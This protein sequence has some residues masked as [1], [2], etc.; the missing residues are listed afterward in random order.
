MA[1]GFSLIEAL[2]ATTILTGALVV[3]TQLALLSIR[4]NQSAGSI[5][6]TTILAAQK[7]EQLRALAWT[8]DAA[9]VPVSDTFTDTTGTEMPAGGTGL[10]LSPSAALEENT[11]GYCDFLDG[12]G[13]TIGRGIN[14]PANTV[15][16]RRWSIDSLSGVAN[17]TLVLQVSVTHI[18][19]RS[20]G[21]RVV[22]I[23]TRK[24]G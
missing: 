4:A 16:V 22:G 14:A 18:G 7:M 21:T 1:R 2:F 17:D 20:D 9:G 6:S 23:R 10:R 5:T 12:N 3:A 19:Q 13:N 24:G 11:A 8:F 15:F